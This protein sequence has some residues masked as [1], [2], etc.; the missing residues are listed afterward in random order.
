MEL[1]RYLTLAG[2]W[3]WLLLV[4]TVVAGGVAFALSRAQTK[5]YQATATVLVNQAQA[6]S[7]PTYNDVLANQ[8]LSKTYAQIVTSLI[9]VR[10]V[11]QNVGANFKDDKTD[12]V[13]SARRDTQLIDIRVTAT[14]PQRAALIADDFARVLADQLRKAQLG[15]QATALSDLEA[16]VTAADAT[17]ADRQAQVARLST[18]RQ[19]NLPEEARLAQLADA[20]AQLD[21]AR[22]SQTLLTRRLQDLRLELSRGINSVTLVSPADVPERA[23]S[24]RVVRTAI[25]GAVLGLLLM[26]GIAAALEYL[27]DTVK[28]GEDVTR[29]AG[30]ATLGAIRR[31]TGEDGPKGAHLISSLES[32]A[33]VAEAYRLVRTNLEFARA[34]MDA[35]TLLVTSASPGEGKSTTAA[36]LALVLAQTGRRVL[37]V[38][39]DM[40]RPRMHKLFDVPNTTGLSTLFVMPAPRLE[41]FVRMTSV[42]TLRLLPSGPL[43]P[44][45]A[46]LL[47]GPRMADLLTLFAAEADFVVV[48]SPPLLG[49]ADASSLAPR[50]D[51]VLLVVDATKTRAGAL[52]HAVE[53]LTRGHATIWGVVLNKLEARRAADSYYYYSYYSYG[54]D[55]PA[56]KNGKPAAKPAPP[57]PAP[58]GRE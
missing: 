2:R 19:P 37:L 15:Q 22:Q 31:F 58:R 38:D 17:L 43:P 53:L 21:T 8:Q 28:S 13:G 23:V 51:G 45:P 36:N 20:Q 40:R 16:Q 11:E 26:V 41:G 50:M 39:A 56:N 35:R 29:A 4:G 55:L 14:D 47:A 46:E 57:V 10:Q 7:G 32:R 30:V 3:W 49:V 44:N 25:L 5:R 54:S 12:V 52:R 48:D 42:E 34:G 27:D 18:P 1:R 9:V 33:P 6:L 24:P